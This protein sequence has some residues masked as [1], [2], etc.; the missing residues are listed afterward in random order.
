[1][2]ASVRRSWVRVRSPM[3]GQE[4]DFHDHIDS[5]P[6]YSSMYN[7]SLSTSNKRL[8]QMNGT[9]T[10]SFFPRDRVKTPTSSLS[11]NTNRQSSGHVYGPRQTT[12]SHNQIHLGASS[13]DS[14]RERNKSA[15]TVGG[16]DLSEYMVN[17]ISGETQMERFLDQLPYWMY[18]RPASNGGAAHGEQ[19][20]SSLEEYLDS[21]GSLMVDSKNHHV[22]S[23]CKCLSPSWMVGQYGSVPRREYEDDSRVDA[24][25][26]LSPMPRSSYKAYEERFTPRARPD[27]RGKYHHPREPDR[28]SPAPRYGTTIP[29]RGT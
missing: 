24:H 4:Q 27:V 22:L 6:E 21:C 26:S 3:H 12:Y 19:Q 16:L 25:S 9:T 29:G 20:E 11:S 10:S 28:H 1:M 14:A 7:D 18:E 5:N 17:K 8:S 15:Y 13:N 2:S 23:Q